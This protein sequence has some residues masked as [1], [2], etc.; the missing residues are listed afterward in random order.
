[1]RRLGIGLAALGVV[2]AGVGVWRLVEGYTAPPPAKAIRDAVHDASAAHSP[3]RGLTATRVSVGGRSVRVVVADDDA[4]RG[5]GLRRRRTL[6][7]YDGMLFAYD[8]DTTVRFTM[9]TVPVP[10]DIAFYDRDGHVVT[11]L[12]MKPCAGTDAQCPLYA[13][14]GPFRYALETLAGRLRSGRLA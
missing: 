4:E 3:F 7:S 10:L 2:I 11:R 1:V 9:S 8:A 12:R 14:S 6:G 5:T 13:S